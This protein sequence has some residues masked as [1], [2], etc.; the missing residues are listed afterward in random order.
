MDSAVRSTT[1][2]IKMS[3][4]IEQYAVAADAETGEWIGEPEFVGVVDSAEWN[5][6]EDTD[7]THYDTYEFFPV[8]EMGRQSI[9]SVTRAIEV[10]WA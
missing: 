6:R 3:K 5:K 10:T 1:Q 2:G 8:D 7:A 9:D 4:Q